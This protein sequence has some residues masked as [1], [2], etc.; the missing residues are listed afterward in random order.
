VVATSAA[1][2]CDFA[3]SSVTSYQRPISAG[4]RV[5]PALD[6]PGPDL[7]H[8]GSVG[9]GGGTL[10]CK[11][12]L[13]CLRIGLVGTPASLCRHIRADDSEQIGACGLAFA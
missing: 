3:F 4:R 5:R 1:P 9:P 7:P 12:W 13:R 11:V 2:F 10:V 6:Q 8:T